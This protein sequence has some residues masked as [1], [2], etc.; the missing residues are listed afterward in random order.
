MAGTLGLGRVAAKVCQAL[1]SVA[2]LAARGNI[3]SSGEFD[4]RH[5]PHGPLPFFFFLID[6]LAA[7]RGIPDLNSRTRN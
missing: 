1:M 2:F 5:V 3:A 6:F 7:L 4:P